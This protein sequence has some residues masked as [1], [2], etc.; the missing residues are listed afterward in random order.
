VTA[1]RLLSANA[2]DHEAPP[3]GQCGPWRW[4]IRDR[5][6]AVFL[7]ASYLT[8]GW[9]PLGG[10]LRR[11]DVIVNHQIEVDDRAATGAPRAYLQRIVRAID[12]S[13]RQAVAGRNAAA[14]RSAVGQRRAIGMMTGADVARA[15]IAVT[16]R[17]KLLVAAWCTAGCTNALRAG[18]RARARPPRV[19][20][21]NLIV[22]IN[23]PCE[24]SALVEA[25]QIATEARVIAMH[26]AEVA[27]VISGLPATGTG[28]DCI[29]VAVPEPK[30]ARRN[31]TIVYCGKHTITGELIAR[32]VMRSCALALGRAMR[33]KPA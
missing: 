23:Q 1:R 31:D 25:I 33:P 15:G 29:T 2:T 20:T 22:V 32:A 11:A 10:G 21:I 26:M 3:A 7:P 18:D 8:L 4:T 9:A 17:G 14:Q 27:S 6:L 28:T 24:R 12:R 16:R 30:R 5:T 13:P 19:G